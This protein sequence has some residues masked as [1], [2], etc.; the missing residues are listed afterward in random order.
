MIL[1]PDLG[2]PIGTIIL[3]QICLVGH[4]E[5]T[6]IEDSEDAHRGALQ[7]N[8]VFSALQGKVYVNANKM[9]SRQ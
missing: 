3:N 7:C 6:V 4:E 1:K 2:T 8:E 9:C 5:E